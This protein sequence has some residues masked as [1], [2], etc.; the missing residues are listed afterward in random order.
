MNYYVHFNVRGEGGKSRHV[1]MDLSEILESAIE[2]MD[3]AEEGFDDDFLSIT[4]S[5][6]TG[7]H[8]Y[9]AQH[10]LTIDFYNDGCAYGMY[11]SAATGEENGLRAYTLGNFELP[12]E[13][14]E[15]PFVTS[16][17]YAGDEETETDSPVA[18]MVHPLRK[19]G[20]NS[21]RLICVDRD[22]ASARSWENAEV[23]ELHGT[24]EEEY[25]HV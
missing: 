14:L 4:A 15:Y 22:F 21:K 6:S 16:R 24:E 10:E 25:R 8:D 18:I 2:D 7:N 1:T 3:G 12:S 11:A 20:D 19:D 23:G 9:N 13:E 5:P 17:L